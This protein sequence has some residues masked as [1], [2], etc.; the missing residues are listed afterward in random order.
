VHGDFHGENVL[1]LDGRVT[2]VIDFGAAGWGS[3][4]IDLAGLLHYA[5]H[6]AVPDT[7][8]R[9]VA[10]RLLAVAGPGALAICLLRQNL[11]L[12]SWAVQAAGA[13]DVAEQ[14]RRGWHIIDDLKSGRVG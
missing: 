7:V 1:A 12:T 11:A 8:R 2:G 3:R 9:R 4:A 6:P 5:Y 13:E 10:A 14:V